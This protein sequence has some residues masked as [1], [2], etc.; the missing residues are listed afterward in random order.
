LEAGGWIESRFFIAEPVVVELDGV[1]HMR[2]G[3]A[4]RKAECER[5][6]FLCNRVEE[7][8]DLLV[9]LLERR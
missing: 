5:R 3:A 6:A 1:N 8:G 7:R 4:M 2:I 9:R